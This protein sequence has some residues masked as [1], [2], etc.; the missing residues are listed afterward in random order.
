MATRLAANENTGFFLGLVNYNRGH[1]Y[2]GECGDIIEFQARTT[3]AKR[4]P[5]LLWYDAA[6]FAGLT[7][8]LL[9]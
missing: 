1:F 7:P 3:T 6:G 4:W 2:C 9:A 8:T 5:L